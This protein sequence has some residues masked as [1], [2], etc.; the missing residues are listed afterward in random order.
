MLL[1]RGLTINHNFFVHDIILSQYFQNKML[2]F[3]PNSVINSCIQMEDLVFSDF[4]AE[5]GVDNIRAYEQEHQEQVT[6]LDKK[7]LIYL[8]YKI[9]NQFCKLFCP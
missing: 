2:I 7:R 8:S 4:C 5:I 9:S 1:T 6:E 3:V